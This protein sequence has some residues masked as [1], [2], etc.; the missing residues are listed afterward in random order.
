MA[1]ELRL[2]IVT[3]LPSLLDSW[4]N[5]SIV[6]RSQAKGVVE[7]EVH[8]LRDCAVNKHGAVDDEPYGGGA[9]MILRPEPLAALIR[10]LKAQRNYDDI[11]YMTPDGETLTQGVSNP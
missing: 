1:V 2:D 3:A 5:N 7:I 9:G 4:L 10:Q 8:N 11:I 6:G